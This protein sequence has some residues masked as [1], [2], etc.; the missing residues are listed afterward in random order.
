MSL[1]MNFDIFGMCTYLGTLP[2]SMTDLSA[3]GAA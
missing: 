2:T 3:A 1:R